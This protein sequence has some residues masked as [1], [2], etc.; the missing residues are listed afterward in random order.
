MPDDDRISDSTE[1]CKLYA[2]FPNSRVESNFWRLRHLRKHDWP[3]FCQ[4]C[5]CVI[6]A[7]YLPLHNSDKQFCK[8][9]TF[10]NDASPGFLP[11]S[12]WSYYPGHPLWHLHYVS[13]WP[14]LG[15]LRLKKQDFMDAAQLF[16]EY[17][18]AFGVVNLIS[19]PELNSSIILLILSF[20]PADFRSRGSFFSTYTIRLEPASAQHHAMD[21]AGFL[22]I[23]GD[24][25]ELMLGNKPKVAKNILCLF[26][27]KSRVMAKHS[28]R[29][30][31]A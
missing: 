18:R 30:G 5:D 1:T 8:Q 6:M 10:A 27:A 22:P 3:T 12:R 13:R 2:T 4:N 19:S 23:L 31:I 25:L 14:V 15:L 9:A 21:R 28:D 24:I 17:N 7:S 26:V 16:V 20:L 29:F 11:R